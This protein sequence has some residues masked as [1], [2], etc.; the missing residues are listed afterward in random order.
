MQILL[1][2][3]FIL[4]AFSLTGCGGDTADAAARF[5]CTKGANTATYQCAHVSN[6]WFCEGDGTDSDGHPKNGLTYNAA[7][8]ACPET[9][10]TDGDGSEGPQKSHGSCTMT[11]A[12]ETITTYY[13][14]QSEYIAATAEM[15]L[16]N[17]M[18][19]AGQHGATITCEN[20]P[21]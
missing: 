4:S 16:L 9:H 10:D 2:C 12:G 18:P 7:V 1:S 17:F 14:D 3:V 6:Q 13:W 11:M 15:S 19:E 8:T 5:V 20:T 21:Q